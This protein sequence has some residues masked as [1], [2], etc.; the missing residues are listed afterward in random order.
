MPLSN[1]IVSGS[2]TLTPEGQIVFS[3]LSAS[4]SAYDINLPYVNAWFNGMN[5]QTT[6]SSILEFADELRAY[7]T[8][9]GK[10]DIWSTVNNTG[11]LINW[12]YY[13]QAPRPDLVIGTGRP[14]VNNIVDD[15]FI[16][17][18]I[19]KLSNNIAG[20]NEYTSRSLPFTYANIFGDDTGNN[21]VG[22][23]NTFFGPSFDGTSDGSS[24]KSRE[25][26]LAW[27]KGVNLQP[28]SEV[29]NNYKPYI[30]A[31]L[32]DPR[33]TIDV[34]IDIGIFLVK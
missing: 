32:L 13:A 25:E 1:F 28:S 29:M 19:L 12:S 6:P 8:F 7:C 31:Y 20:F 14:V 3:I 11:A 17:D 26:I 34:N 18:R 15:I 22:V 16:Q 33:K 21:G 10:Q 2:L 30:Q 5:V 23:I 4:R 24:T 9:N 27:F